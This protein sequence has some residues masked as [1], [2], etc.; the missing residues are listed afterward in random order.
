VCEREIERV[1]NKKNGVG[2]K[3]T[4]LI[5]GVIFF[6]FEDFGHYYLQKVEK[7]KS[8]RFS[9]NRGWRK[10]GFKLVEI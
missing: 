6:L 7:I 5:V 1:R 9:E 2:G 10:K 4:A 8:V 3:C